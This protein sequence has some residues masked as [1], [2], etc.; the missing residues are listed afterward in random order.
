VNDRLLRRAIRRKAGQARTQASSLVLRL[1]DLMRRHIAW[2]SLI[3][4]AIESRESRNHERLGCEFES[5]EG[6]ELDAIPTQIRIW[7]GKTPGV[8]LIPHINK[9]APTK[10]AAHLAPH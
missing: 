5:V 3:L 8:A 7:P 4:I 9:R 10:N 1:A 6:I 2:R